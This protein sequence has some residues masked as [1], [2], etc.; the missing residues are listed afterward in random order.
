M[1]DLRCTTE[2]IF[3]GF[4]TELEET[5]TKYKRALDEGLP[6]SGIFEITMDNTST[7]CRIFSPHFTE[8]LMTKYSALTK[9]KFQ[10]TGE[11]LS[12]PDLEFK[13]NTTVLQLRNIIVQV[14]DSEF[15]HI[16]DRMTSVLNKL[17]KK[18]LE[19]D[20]KSGTVILPLTV[21][22][23][24]ELAMPQNKQQLKQIISNNIHC[25]DSLFQLLEYSEERPYIP[26]V[27]LHWD[28]EEIFF[29]DEFKYYTEKYQ[30]ILQGINYSE[31]VSEC[32]SY[33]AYRD[34][35]LLDFGKKQRGL[36]YIFN[37]LRGLVFN[38]ELLQIYWQLFQECE[39]NTPNVEV[40]NK[41][42]IRMLFETIYGN[43][44]NKEELDKMY[45]LLFDIVKVPKVEAEI[46]AWVKKIGLYDGFV[47]G[48]HDIYKAL[49]FL[50]Y[51]RWDESRFMRELNSFYDIC[52]H[53]IMLQTYVNANIKTNA[54]FIKETN[55]KFSNLKFKKGI[56]FLKKYY[57]YKEKI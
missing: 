35:L 8:K 27:L 4:L 32:K 48:W 5:I 17:R 57:S 34:Y 19:D 40:N 22:A 51:I 45:S 30:G 31:L 55:K 42:A 36:Q 52:G 2:T 9:L 18:Q 47:Y 16:Q 43:S 3:E 50:D 21:E 13:Q 6:Y 10:Y 20:I 38:L 46:L 29:L 37:D 7:L 54:N 26:I 12:T 28:F 23:L 33:P 24:K 39:T 49:F 56:R 41:F 1:A 44:E 14:L 11:Q 15:S 25:L 53:K